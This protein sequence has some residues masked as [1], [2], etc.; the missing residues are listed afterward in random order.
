M[1]E[2]V[3][4][5][6][7]ERAYT[8][9]P[10]QPRLQAKVWAC[11]VNE[12]FESNDKHR[13]LSVQFATRLLTDKLVTADAV[14]DAFENVLFPTYEDQDCPRL[15]Q[16]TAAYLAAVA[17]TIGWGATV[18][19]LRCPHLDFN[20]K[21]RAVALGPLLSSLCASMVRIWKA[22]SEVVLL[23]CYSRFTHV[24]LL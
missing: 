16:Y 24:F 23:A 22:G 2:A 13:S 7:E 14:A 15:P 4:C 21:F 8:S 10:E 12:S 9:L 19:V 5:V 3:A 6:R 20:P 17:Q 11:I 18:R 1:K